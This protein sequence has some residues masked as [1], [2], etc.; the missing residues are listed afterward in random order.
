[1]SHCGIHSVYEAAYHGV[2]LVGVPFMFEQ[3]RLLFTGKVRF[4]NC[5]GLRV[6]PQEVSNTACQAHPW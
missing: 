1:M 5:A 2:P 3:V 4:R 6:G